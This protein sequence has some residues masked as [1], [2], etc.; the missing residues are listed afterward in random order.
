MR[1]GRV[2]GATGMR[3]GRVG[4]AM[5]MRCGRVGGAMGMRCGRV[6]WVMF[7]SSVIK[8]VGVFCSLVLQQ[9]A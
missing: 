2:G 9:T 1:C 7:T 4:G 5:G 6:G 8:T 3:C